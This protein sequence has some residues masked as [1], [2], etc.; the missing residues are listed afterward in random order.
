MSWRPHAR[1]L[2]TSW[3]RY[4]TFVYLEKEGVPQQTG[5]FCP[6]LRP[7]KAT[8]I[9]SG[10]QLLAIAAGTSVDQAVQEYVA[11]G[12]SMSS[13]VSV[14]RGLQSMLEPPAPVA[15][16]RP[17]APDIVL[18]QWQ[19]DLLEVVNRE[20]KPRAIQWLYGPP[21]CGK[22][23]FTT[24]LGYS[25]NYDGGL[26]V[27]QSCESLRNALNRYTNQALVVFDYPFSFDWHHK[28]DSVGTV[29]EC[30]SEYGARRESEKYQ[31]RSV[32]ICCHCVVFANVPPIDQVSHRDV[33][34]TEI[35]PLL[36]E[37]QASTLVMGP[38]VLTWCWNCGSLPIA[39]RR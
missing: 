19:K 7:S 2:S 21:A 30:F 8:G 29:L 20:P 39:E 25:A 4:N 12:G 31:G 32:Q 24:W 18:Q 14:R 34:V 1:V 6:P 17:S 28:A 3:H 16:F 10:Q 5:R 13:V 37:S 9:P 35:P 38:S 22:T 26:V 23:T 33:H 36:A 27:F 15:R 11:Q